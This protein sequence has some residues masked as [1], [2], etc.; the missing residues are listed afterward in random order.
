MAS[1]NVRNAISHIV[2]RQ[3]LGSSLFRHASTVNQNSPTVDTTAIVIKNEVGNS[4]ESIDKR[5]VELHRADP[6]D[7]LEVVYD[8]KWDR[9]IDPF[10]E[11]CDQEFIDELCPP[12]QPTFNITSLVN[13]SSTLKK[14][15]D[16]GVDLFHLEQNRDIAEYIIRLDFD[17]HIK[18]HIFFLH[19]YGFPDDKLGSFITK[20]PLIFQEAIK[21][22]QTRLRFLKD[23]GFTHDQILKILI[24]H[25][26]FINYGVTSIQ[27]LFDFLRGEYH[28]YKS[29]IPHVVSTYPRMISLSDMYFRVS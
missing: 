2:R 11:E 14:L 20:N 26:V 25:P 15:V 19:H 16:L 17:Q 22:L 21:N 18:D 3:C 13:Q 4:L 28:L 10:S 12:P 24:S 7:S 29:N 9:L 1:V 8:E 23:Y 6:D 5:L 27:Q